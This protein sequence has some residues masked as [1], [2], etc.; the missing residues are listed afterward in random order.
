MT[1]MEAFEEIRHDPRLPEI[2]EK[3]GE[4]LKEERKRREQFYRD[5]TPEQ[6]IEF[7]DG[8]VILHSPAKNRHLDVTKYAL[9]LIDTFVTI[10]Q[11]GTVKC[12]KCLTVFPRNDY[13]PD[14]VYFGPE[15]AATLSA[16]TM[17]FPIPDL[18]VEVL[19]SSTEARDRGI[20]FTDYAANGVEEY[21]IIDPEN[22]VLEQYFLEKGD[23]RLHIKASKTSHSLL[24]SR[25]IPNLEVPVEAI[26]DEAANLAA[27]ENLM[28]P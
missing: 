20:N 11:L 1:A 16:D 2:Y 6:K 14:I 7:I 15:K 17:K 8:E 21:W 10:R 28:A 4:Q 9:K 24:Q 3:I 19:S 5:M 27:L 23:F 18:I 22:E 13:E 26:F 12:E 25:A